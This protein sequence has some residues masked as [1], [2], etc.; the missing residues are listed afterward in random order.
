MFICYWFPYFKVQLLKQIAGSSP[1]KDWKFLASS[2]VV[3]IGLWEPHFGNQGNIAHSFEGF[4]FLIDS[5]LIICDL[6]YCFLTLFFCKGGLRKLLGGIILTCFSV[7]GFFLFK[8]CLSS[9]FLCE[10]K[11]FFF[12][13]A[14]WTLRISL[15]PEENTGIWLSESSPPPASPVRP[16]HP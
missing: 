1:R 6:L 16:S 4:F 2:L 5:P 12:R 15:P 13:K 7:F 14:E 8:L 11:L 3:H 9:F 10:K